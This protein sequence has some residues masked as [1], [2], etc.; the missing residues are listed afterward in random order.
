MYL[1]DSPTT[2]SSGVLNMYYYDIDVKTYYKTFG[3]IDYVNGVVYMDA[4]EI[5]G[6]D[7]T[8]GGVFDLIIKPQSNDVVSVRNQL[9]TIPDSHISVT[10]VLDKV[11][12]GDPAGGAN[13]K[14]TSSRN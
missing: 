8:N 11:S 6:I 10:M 5:T 3:S 14:F 7:Q 9:V 2:T 1:E 13:Y 4:L 12:V